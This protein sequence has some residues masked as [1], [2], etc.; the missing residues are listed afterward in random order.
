MSSVRKGAYAIITT[1][2]TI[3]PL[4][5]NAGNTA[6][7]YR[8]Y[9]GQGFNNETLPYIIMRAYMTSG[10]YTKQKKSSIDE[11]RL[12]LDIYADEIA[13]AET[14]GGYCRTAL[15]GYSG[16]VN[17]ANIDGCRLD[18]EDEDVDEQAT[19]F[20]TQDYQ[21]RIGR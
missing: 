8:V 11:F 15:E 3:G 7:P 18:T 21:I 14:I 17:G 4:V 20:W 10:S 2:L 16:V 12:E 1:D 6:N 19:S 13:T 9:L 5:E